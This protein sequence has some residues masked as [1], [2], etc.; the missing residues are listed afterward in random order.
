MHATSE[1]TSTPVNITTQQLGL[2]HHTMGLSPH[3]RGESRNYFLAGAGHHDQPNLLELVAVGFMVRSAAP[4]WVGSGDLFRVT[5]AGRQYAVANMPPVPAPV[6]RT[7]YDEYLRADVGCTFA[8]WLGIEVPRREYE[9]SV[10][11]KTRRVRLVSSK[12]RGAWGATVKEAKT[13]YKSAL[14][15]ANPAATRHYSF[16]MNPA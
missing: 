1:T 10:Y 9:G 14:A 13:L 3:Q 12:A 6:K 5:E 16:T 4:S 11:A 8:E 2:L 7:K 15:A